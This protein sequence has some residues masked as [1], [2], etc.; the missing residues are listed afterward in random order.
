MFKP[1]FRRPASALLFLSVALLGMAQAG[2]APVFL[3]KWGELCARN[4]S[5]CE[6]DFSLPSDAVVTG[7]G[8]IIVSESGN[9]RMQEL[10]R[11]GEFIAQWGSQCNVFVEGPNGCDGD[12]FAPAGT[13]L[14]TSGNLYVADQNNDRVQKFD[15]DHNFVDKWG[16]AG[17][18][19]GQ[20]ANPAGVAIDA[21]GNIWV[22]DTDNHRIQKL[23]SSGVFQKAWGYG[24]A[25][26]SAVE[27]CIAGCQAGLPL[28]NDGAFWNP[29]GMAIDASG[30]IY[31]ADSGNHRIQKFD[32]GGNFLKK[33]GKD[34][35]SGEAGG[36][37][38]EFNWPTGIAINTAGQIVVV[39]QTG[40]RAQLFDLQANFLTKW[41]A[42]GSGDG[43]FS[44]P[45][46]V[47]FDLVGNVYVVDSGN[48]LMQKFGGLFR[49]YIASLPHR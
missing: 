36:D 40:N 19:G 21:S 25:G 35:G 2:P 34:G 28:A 8:N 27:S 49:T 42:N 38:G 9:H 29:R 20:F 15:R 41:G 31:V 11:T 4:G 24:V 48:H 46:G 43:E 26:G 7:N 32:S 17:T 18:D 37:D 23:N 1:R 22:S 14:D 44:N 6:G 5:L 12:F 39:E 3:A 10:T 45:A 30:N 47:A 33:W 13:A 16:I